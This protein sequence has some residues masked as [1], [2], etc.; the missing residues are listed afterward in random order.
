MDRRR[1]KRIHLLARPDNAA[2]QVSIR[3]ARRLCL[4]EP[5]C[6]CAK[7]EA[8]P[9]L[10]ARANISERNL[11]VQHVFK[12]LPGRFQDR[13]AACRSRMQ[14]AVAASLHRLLSYAAATTCCG[15]N[16]FDAS[17]S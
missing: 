11:R 4:R 14:E 3:H 17:T 13:R 12:L 15:A 5:A 16:C 10:Q 9:D 7:G 1:E 8:R 6:G 2:L